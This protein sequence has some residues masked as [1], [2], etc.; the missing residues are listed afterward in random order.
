MPEG[1]GPVV[2]GDGEIAQT[3]E[4][5]TNVLT[6]STT[7]LRSIADATTHL[8]RHLL[9]PEMQYRLKHP[10]AVE[11]V[12]ALVDAGDPCFKVSPGVSWVIW[13]R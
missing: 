11:C 7:L 13:G 3:P 9:T 8:Q 6:D 12:K 4:L 2:Q 5:S 1:P 10:V